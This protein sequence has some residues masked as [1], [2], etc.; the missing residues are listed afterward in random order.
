MADI[1]VI[2]NPTQIQQ[3]RGSK[4]YNSIVWQWIDKNHYYNS[5]IKTM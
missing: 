3:P 4:L 1:S 2:H 5:A